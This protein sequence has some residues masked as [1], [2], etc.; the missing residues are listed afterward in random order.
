MGFVLFPPLATAN[1][2]AKNMCVH[3]FECLFSILLG[4]SL[5]VKLLG[6]TVILCL[7]FEVTLSS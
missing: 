3:V 4:K 6:H 2:T 5:K 1:S 7:T